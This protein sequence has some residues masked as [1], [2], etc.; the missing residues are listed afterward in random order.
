MTKAEVV[1]L[2]TLATAAYPAAQAKD[3]EPVVKAWRLL[4]PELSFPVAKAALFKVC[5]TSQF[6]P[7]V[8]DIAQAAA[9]LD[10][11]ADRLPTAAEAWEEV[12]GLIRTV[13]P[14]RAPAYSCDTVRR[15]AQSIG[16]RQ[17]CTG[18]NPEADRAHFLKIYES[19]RE[20]KL[21]AREN[22][23]A[24]KISG[25]SDVL[26]MRTGKRTGGLTGK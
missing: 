23:T 25:A 15:A 11:R 4:L 17:L 19:L 7:S 10:P 13:G 1:A 20:R 24:L 18:E 8:A 21:A 2:V 16:W 9:E 26:K 3:P 12:A 22:E 5:R 6:F 14:Y